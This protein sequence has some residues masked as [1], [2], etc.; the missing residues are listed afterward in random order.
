MVEDGQ[1]GPGFFGF[2]E[3]VWFGSFAIHQHWHGLHFGLPK[4]GSLKHY[5]FLRGE[6]M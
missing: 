1:G 3:V 4:P 5:G 2:G 6:E